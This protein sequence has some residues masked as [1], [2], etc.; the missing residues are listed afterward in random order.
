MNPVSHV[1]LGLS[2]RLS[3]EPRI[4]HLKWAVRSSEVNLWFFALLPFGS[5]GRDLG[6][7][8]VNCTPTAL[9]PYRSA[10]A[11][12]L[13]GRTPIRPWSCR[14]RFSRWRGA[15]LRRA[16]R[17][18]TALAACAAPTMSSTRGNCRAACLA[19]DARSCRR[20]RHR[21]AASARCACGRP[22]PQAHV[23]RLHHLARILD[24][25]LRHRRDL[26]RAGPLSYVVTANPTSRRPKLG[27]LM[28]RQ[29]CRSH[30]FFR[31]SLLISALRR[32]ASGQLSSSHCKQRCFSHL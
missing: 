13:A 28:A 6:H 9:R 29:K 7:S 4:F 1:H 20:V 8:S 17:R 5:P 16:L 25:G 15:R 2:N 26:V 22:R 3:A 12:D 19:P 14:S 11:P 10:S 24:E 31:R 32:R 23:A 27:F 21:D 30:R 18:R